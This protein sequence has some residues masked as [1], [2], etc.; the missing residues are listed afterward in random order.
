[1]TRKERDTAL[2]NIMNAVLKS[3]HHLEEVLTPLDSPKLENLAAELRGTESVVDLNYPFSEIDMEERNKA[4]IALR[5]LWANALA[6][7]NVAQAGNLTL[8]NKYA[9]IIRYNGR[10]VEFTRIG[11]TRE[12]NS[13]TG[14]FDG[15][16]TD[17]SISMYLSAAVDAAK[18]PIQIDINDNTFTV[19]VAGL[20]LS[21]G[22]PV[23]DVVYFLAQPSIQAAIEHA[24]VNDYTLGQLTKSIS[25]QAG[26]LKGKI[27]SESNPVMDSE[28]LRDVSGADN[29]KHFHKLFLA[30]RNLQTVYKIITPDN[31]SN[32]NEMS[33]ITSWIDTEVRFSNNG[34]DSIVRGAENFIGSESTTYPVMAAYRKYFD[35]VLAA[36]ETVGFV[37][38][39]PSFFAFKESL[40]DKIGKYS[41]SAA[42]H[43]F[44]DRALVLK[45][46]AHPNSPLKNYL[47]PEAFNRMY[48]NPTDNIATELAKIKAK[49][50]KI[51]T[52][53]FVSSLQPDSANT[54][55][56]TIYKIKFDNSFDM[57][58]HDKNKYTTGMFNLIAKPEMFAN[59]PSDPAELKEIRN[60]GRMLVSNQLLSDG[61]FPGSGSYIDLVPV[62]AWTT[63]MLFD[64]K[65]G[66]TPVEFFNG[67]A[68]TSLY[69]QDFFEGFQHEFV[70]NFGLAKPGGTPFLKTVKWRGMPGSKVNPKTGLAKAPASVS[71]PNEDS[72]VYDSTLGYVGYFVTYH[73]V[74]G[75]LVYSR[76]DTNKY[77]LMNSLGENKRVHEIFSNQTN[78]NSLIPGRVGAIDSPGRNYISERS[79]ADVVLHESVEKPLK[80]CKL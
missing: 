28:E 61:Y 62:E 66:M 64:D 71:F 36:A 1:M 33:A 42:Q 9:P 13:A 35:T 43:K 38:N 49:Y 19:P 41:L 80:V 15:A 51:N 60:F 34:A 17:S 68:N 74:D 76:E 8:S 21:V 67:Q 69:N 2:F 5:G 23:E 52:N 77:S 25:V 24:K 47:S 3:D 11:V 37:N 79:T 4:G 30:G 16:Y 48:T 18:K 31:V 27:E 20:M 39:R 32:S 22:V 54:K 65:S 14:E 63:T 12:Y 78:S 44:I 7:R 29:V 53:P 75:P 72:R 45:V 56:S 55:S 58:A 26:I 70:R 10:E 6:G 46:M 73:P 57:S 50:N 59:D 40:K